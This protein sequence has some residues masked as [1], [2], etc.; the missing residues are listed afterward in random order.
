MECF[1]G[2]WKMK[3]NKHQLWIVYLDEDDNKA[4]HKISVNDVIMH[5]EH[6]FKRFVIALEGFIIE[7]D[8]S[9]VYIP[10][11]RI[12][13]IFVKKE[14]KEIWGLDKY[15]IAKEEGDGLTVECPGCH[16]AFKSE[17]ECT[18]HIDKAMGRIKGD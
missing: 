8:D 14:G 11:H 9:Y 4:L 15:D 10:P 1:Q 7:S 17:E 12:C 16:K 13:K 3:D 6:G 5:D 18:L 2:I